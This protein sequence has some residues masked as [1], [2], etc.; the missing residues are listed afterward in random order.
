[1]LLEFSFKN[2]F[3]FKEETTINMEATAIEENI[4][5]VLE[6]DIGNSVLKTMVF[7]GANSSGKTNVFKVFPTFVWMVRNSSVV[8][9]TSPIGRSAFRFINDNNEEDSHIAIKALIDNV[10]YEYGFSFDEKT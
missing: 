8:N 2:L 4:D 9:H 10:K 3:S 1:M 7:A 5:N 6:T